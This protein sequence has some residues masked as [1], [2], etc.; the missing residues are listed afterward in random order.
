MTIYKR[1]LVRKLVLESGGKCSAGQQWEESEKR[2]DDITTV[3]GYKE[4]CAMSNKWFIREEITFD[5][6][7]YAQSVVYTLLWFICMLFYWIMDICMT[8]QTCLSC[9]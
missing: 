2:T 1:F 7:P 8:C 6:R 9:S 5:A 4:G 3:T